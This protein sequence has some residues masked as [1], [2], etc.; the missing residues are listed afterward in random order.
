MLIFANCKINL[1]LDVVARRP[2]GYHELCTV[3]LPVPGLCDAVELVAA[4]QD[5]LTVYGPPVD[6]PPERNLCM[7]A[8]RLMQERHGAGHAHIH[9]QKAVPSGAGLGG[10][11][12]DAA[13]VVVA[14]N[15]LFEL[16]L[17]AG[18]MEEAAAAL[19]SD[20]PFFIRN[21][22]ALATGRG[23][24][25][26]PADAAILEKLA[27]KYLLIVK[28][29]VAV[30]TAEAYAGITPVVPAVALEERLGHC[31]EAWRWSVGNAFE[32]HIFA[33]HPSLAM[34]KEMLYAL[35]AQYASMS[36]SGSALYGIFDRC[37][38]TDALPQDLF[39]HGEIVRTP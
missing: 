35:G 5:A 22:P 2:D 15:T 25:L 27:G 12:S 16:G 37:P 33:S 6:C 21:Q 23:E 8:L 19:G 9:L 7:K 3:M 4:G 38:A 30:S 36:G 14:C 32:R 31:V 39:I 10:G 1:G 17:S 24:I 20:V 11:S 18:Q 28:P 13:A 29:D 26:R 34:L